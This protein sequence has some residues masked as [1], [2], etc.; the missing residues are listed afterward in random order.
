MSAGPIVPA[1]PAP[2]AG[3]LFMGGNAKLAAKTNHFTKL[4]YFGLLFGVCHAGG[5]Y[6][7][8][9]EIPLMGD[10]GAGKGRTFPQMQQQADELF[11][12][13]K[14]TRKQYDDMST[15]LTT[16]PIMGNTLFAAST[17]GFFAEE[18][19]VKG[20]TALLLRVLPYAAYALCPW[21]GVAV[22]VASIGGMYLAHHIRTSTTEEFDTMVAG[23]VKRIKTDQDL[24]AYNKDMET[25]ISAQEKKHALTVRMHRSIKENPDSTLFVQDTMTGYLYLKD[26]AAIGVLAGDFPPRNA[27]TSNEKYI[28]QLDATAEQPPLSRTV[29]RNL[30]HDGPMQDWLRRDPK[31][32]MLYYNYLLDVTSKKN[33]PLVHKDFEE[34]SLNIAALKKYQGATINGYNA[35]KELKRLQL[36]PQSSLESKDTN[37]AEMLTPGATPAV[38][39]ANPAIMLG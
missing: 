30:L 38:A 29:L 35:E 17:V 6:L 12:Q 14:I 16:T 23:T 37:Y 7:E 11:K 18:A 2:P 39:T 4:G 24:A 10:C 28:D 15:L 9:M 13:G 1:V 8:E 20:G 19:L 25:L 33:E 27:L 21:L 32:F 3:P 31:A 36:I 34:I 5:Y 22:T 26:A